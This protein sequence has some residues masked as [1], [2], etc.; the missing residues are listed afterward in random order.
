MT[1]RFLSSIALGF[2]VAFA[3]L[4]PASAEQLQTATSS[5]PAKAQ[6]TAKAS[7]TAKPPS[8]TKAASAKASRASKSKH[9]AQ[10]TTPA[11]TKNTTNEVGWASW[12]GKE[13]QGRKTAG[14]KS[15][16]KETMV[17]AHRTLPMGSKVRITN[18]SNGKSIDVEVVDRGPVRH[19]R[20]IDLSEGAARAID[21]KNAGVAKVLVEPLPGDP[22]RVQTA[23][24]D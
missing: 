12:Y 6:S 18:L 22:T 4:A 2:A 16:D 1:V 11:H 7:S 23:T 9:V 10:S 3:T 15:F 13:V 21:M 17:A 14:G 20:V 8:P 24:G 5:P 19:D